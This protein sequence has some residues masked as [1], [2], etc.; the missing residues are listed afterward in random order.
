MLSA[1]AEKT[2]L[3]INYD[4]FELSSDLCTKD[5]DEVRDIWIRRGV[6]A[7]AIAGLALVMAPVAALG[8]T[9]VLV[10]EAWIALHLIV[11]NFGWDLV[12]S[13]NECNR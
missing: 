8:G 3:G 13:Y 6:N 11:G 12:T 5:N 2:K 10:A 1:I 4:F 7:A 9:A